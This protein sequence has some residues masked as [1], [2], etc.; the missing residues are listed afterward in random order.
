M[1]LLHTEVPRRTGE[2]K[3]RQPHLLTLIASALVV[4]LSLG[5]TPMHAR[6]PSLSISKS[7][8][9]DTVDTGV[10]F[11]WTIS[12]SISSTNDPAYDVVITDVLPP[13]LLLAAG[14]VQLIGNPQTASTSYNP[15]T[16]AAVFTMVNPLP[17]GSSGQLQINAMFPPGTT[18]NGTIACNTATIT[19]SNA[20]TVTSNQ[21]C[22]VA[23]AVHRFTFQKDHYAGNAL[24]GT[25]IYRLRV[26]NP[27]G[28][29]IGGLN[30]NGATFSDTLQTGAV[31]VSATGTH[32]VVGQVVTWN[33]GNLVVSPWYNPWYVDYFLTVQYPSPPFT[34]GQSVCNTGWLKGT[35]V[36]W[37]GTFAQKDS[38]CLTLVAPQPGVQLLKGPYYSPMTNRV[39]GC[40]G[41]YSLTPGN[42][43][44]VA[45]DSFKV[46][47]VLPQEVMVTSFSTGSYTNFPSNSVTIRYR[48]TVNPSWT[49]AGPFVGYQNISVYGTPS[50]TNLGLPSGVYL[51]ELQW[52]YG[53]APVG[54]ATSIPAYIYFTLLTNNY[55]TNALVVP[56]N[57]VTNCATLTW[58]YASAPGT[59]VTHC[60]QFTVDNP[61]PVLSLNK[62]ELSQGPYFPG[63]TIQFRIRFWNIGAAAL[64]GV[65][66]TDVLPV[67]LQ[68][69]NTVSYAGG[70]GGPNPTTLGPSISTAGQT[71]T[72][73]FSQPFPA[74]AC[75]TGTNFWYDIVFNAVVTINTPPGTVCNTYTIAAT[76]HPT[77]GSNQACVVINS[78]PTMESQKLVRGSLDSTYTLAGSTVAGGSADY[79]LTVTNTGN[80]TMKDILIVDILPFPGDVGVINWSVSRGSTWQ[81][82]LIAPITAP[83]GTSVYYSMETAPCRSDLGLSG[84]LGCTGPVWYTYA[85][86]IG[87]GYNITQVRSVKL[88]F[89]T[90]QL[91]PGQ[92]VAVTWPMTAPAGIPVGQLACN[93]FGYRARRADNNA[94]VGPAEPLKVCVQIRPTQGAS[95]GDFVWIDSDMDGVQDVGESGLNGVQV[96]LWQVGPDNTPYTGDDAIA[97]NLASIPIPFVMTANNGIGQPGYYL[98]T[99]LPPNT[100]YVRFSVPPMFTPTLLN[101][102]T[103]A[104][105]SD[106]DPVPGPTFGWTA[107]FTLAANAADTTID[108]GLHERMPVDCSGFRADV[109]P[110]STGACCWDLTFSMPPPSA[111]MTIA[112]TAPSTLT[113]LTPPTGWTATPALGS[114][115]T[116]SVDVTPPAGQSGGTSL[117]QFCASS[118][119]V[120]PQEFI[121]TWTDAAGMVLCTDTVRTNCPKDTTG[122]GPG[123]V[124]FHDLDADGKQG[125]A[126]PGLSDWTILLVPVGGGRPLST[127][128]RANGSYQFGTVPAGVYHVVEQQQTGWVQTAPATAVQQV[129][130]APGTT[131]P[132]VDFGNLV[133]PCDHPTDTIR[134]V[135]GTV[136]QFVGPEPSS[137][138]ASL[139][140]WNTANY[141]LPLSGFDSEIKEQKGTFFGHTFS[142]FGKPGCWLMG[143][144]LRIR[145]RAVGPTSPND[146]IGFVA[147]STL[148]WYHTIAPLTVPGTWTPGQTATLIL[149]LGAL[150]PG[151]NNGS[152]S[153]LAAMA[154]GTFNIFIQN[155][156][157]VDYI[158]LEVYI[159][160][161]EAVGKAEL[162]GCKFHDLDGDGVWD[163]SEPTLA[164]WTVNLSNGQSVTTGQDGCYSITVPAPGTYVVSETQVLPW[165]QTFPSSP[166]THTV[167]VQPGQTVSNLNFGNV[168]HGQ[169]GT[170]TECDSLI[171]STV[172][173]A[174]C[175][176][177]ATIMNNV[178]APITSISWSITGG[179]MNSFTTTPCA[180][181]TA[182]APG[183]TSGVLLYSPPCPGN[184]AFSIAATPTTAS[185]W[186]SV[187]LVVHH[188][189]KDSC[190][191]TFRW[192]CERAPVTACD[193][194]NVKPFLFTGL[195]LSGR[196][197]TVFNVK[198]P[199]SPITSIDIIGT[200]APCFLQ[201][202][203]L[204][205]D[206]VATAWSVPYTRIPI[207]GS[208]S[209]NSTVKF[210]LGVDYTC[211]WTGAIS[212]VIHHADG[213]SCLYTYGPWAATP[214]S[215]TGGVVVSSPVQAKRLYANRLRV[216]NTQGRAP[217]KWVSVEV[218]DPTDRMFAGSGVMW[219]G[220]TREPGEEPLGEHQQGRAE[221][222]FGLITPVLPGRESESLNLVVARD[223]ARAGVPSIR[224][225]TYDER[226]NALTSDTL[227]LDVPVLS[228]RNDAPSSTAR[229][230]ELLSAFPNPATNMTT[231]NYLLGS[232]MDLEIELYDMTGARMALVES[233]RRQ[234]G[235]HA[236][237]VNLGSL[238]AGTYYLQMRTDAGVVTK[239][240]TIAR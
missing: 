164:G 87:G 114:Y 55:V 68:Y 182:P 109:K 202:G 100:Y 118:G 185:G 50:S 82:N 90:L 195:D 113:S 190:R 167:T 203:A 61:Q 187:T 188:G 43:G 208:I 218:L 171:S 46:T 143:A 219:D 98:F 91:S 172:D 40:T 156:T 192:K 221:A 52:D 95:V 223:S 108:M 151:Q 19:A 116:S 86:L 193:S 216:R 128:T 183:S 215:T 88:D 174:C 209:A 199:A 81:A 176:Y 75:G 137:P 33:L 47:D 9:V 105:D 36:G 217:V 92:S 148:A 6:Q 236:V 134:I 117:L 227:R 83:P 233:G 63:D 205:I 22:V 12:Y 196:T 189:E 58:Q 226:G 129:T 211:G 152:T 231:V 130:V 84:P 237:R 133:P 67:G 8:S 10:L 149:D 66:V 184:M 53:T 11:T 77:V 145:I 69:A 230:F 111:M 147:G 131:L 42:T 155:H 154:G 110:N 220:T 73:S 168:K 48:T 94:L 121:I 14:N 57:I 32:T 49:T 123:G 35:P 96:E 214:P 200:P 161:P 181:Y 5:A 238:P 163:P 180:S 178:G 222:L 18:P 17:A 99:N 213:D 106:A 4:M 34:Q 138:S 25:V 27:T 191:L 165:V 28:N 112:A 126:E 207:A 224:W 93:S 173:S 169:G 135:A 120:T 1:N 146:G 225:T 102:G 159:C 31:Y 85:G 162:K 206:A 54:F 30:L 150:V 56:G 139:L 212:L 38:A 235:V 7:A 74:A 197:F 104:D 103:P 142:G 194:V 204:S 26:I 16:G 101:A 177:N 2:R 15:I 239:P 201:G 179:T 97:V 51:T 198:V 89:G 64:T 144:K 115:P 170:T 160:C 166:A 153:V 41:F 45:V 24:N 240:L 78:V 79:Q 76:N 20:A 175:A 60:K 44:N 229:G 107:P 122:T 71:V 234:T 127:R 158:G 141:G 186:V 232:E 210:N 62:A 37:T 124:K 29:S 140:A 157:I 228:V 70:G 59:P 125:P 13:Q 65:V 21:V 3:P 132:P 136:D 72:W 23:R 119:G 39:P 80:V